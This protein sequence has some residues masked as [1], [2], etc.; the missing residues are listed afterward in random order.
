MTAIE[1][2][3]G[4]APRSELTP[5]AIIEAI[6]KGPPPE[7]PS[8]RDFSPEFRQFV[9]N[10]LQTD[11]NRRVPAS[12][13]LLSAFIQKARDDAYIIE[14]IFFRKFHRLNNV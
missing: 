13:L 14:S 4:V 10:C 8:G 11:P 7:L 3:V 9:Q 12:Q 1:V 6:L 2:A 5:L